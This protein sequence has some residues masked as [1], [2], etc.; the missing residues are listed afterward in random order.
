MVMLSTISAG[1]IVTRPMATQE[2][3][4]DG[5][6]WFLTGEE[7]HKVVELEK[8]PRVGLAYS[9]EG[10]ESYVSVSGTARVTNDRALIRK[11]WNPFL[12]AWFDGP[13]D[14]NIRVIEVT[15]D[16]AEYWSTKGGKLVSLASV[17]LS[18]VT[19]KE[20]EAGENRVL[21]F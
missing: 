6:L 17:F 4:K 16:T 8:D 19:G 21:A 7:S 3:G 2:M 18:A 5:T 9:D 1:R 13:D 20:L 10:A 14:P 11:F 15:P 12:K